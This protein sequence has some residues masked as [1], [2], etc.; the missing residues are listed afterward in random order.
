M[1]LIGS[2]EANHSAHR[3]AAYSMVEGASESLREECTRLCSDE[4]RISGVKGNVKME[5][6]KII[7]N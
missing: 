4:A 3:M 2:P 1:C 5:K 7:R 6:G